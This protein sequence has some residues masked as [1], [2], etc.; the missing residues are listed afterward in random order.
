[1][2]WHPGK[3]IKHRP[4]DEHDAVDICVF[5]P[6][7]AAVL[8]IQLFIRRFGLYPS[9]AELGLPPLTRSGQRCRE[10]K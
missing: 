8:L 1:M 9:H 10:I 5:S 4:S 6:F 3:M 7:R 2:T